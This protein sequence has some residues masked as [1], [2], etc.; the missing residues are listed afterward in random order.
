[1]NK[2]S[3]SILSLL[4]LVSLAHCGEAINYLENTKIEEYTANDRPLQKVLEEMTALVCKTYPHLKNFSIEIQGLKATEL[5]E[6]AVTFEVR[7]TTVLTVL[8]VLCNQIPGLEGVPPVKLNPNEKL[9]WKE[10][11]D[12]I[13]L[14]L[15]VK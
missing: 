10:R 7:D 9:F 5:G 14:S 6:Q 2:K 3:I 11:D 4:F 8:K 13:I 12:K 1:M 15:T